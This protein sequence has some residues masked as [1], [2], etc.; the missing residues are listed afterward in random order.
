MGTL[1]QNEIPSQPCCKYC[2]II[3][4]VYLSKAVENLLLAKPLCSPSTEAAAL[5]DVEH[6]RVEGRLVDQV[7]GRVVDQVEG[8]VEV[9]E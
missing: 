9:G 6:G 2:S 3:S 4:S 5:A 1:K 8:G 7:E